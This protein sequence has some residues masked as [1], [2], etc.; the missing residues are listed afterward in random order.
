ML[1][2][3]ASILLQFVC[4]RR[5]MK[6]PRTTQVSPKVARNILDRKAIVS[7]LAGSG[8]REKIL[9]REVAA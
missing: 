7:Y 6:T 1:P 8:R 9:V 4:I 2:S 5:D 3:V